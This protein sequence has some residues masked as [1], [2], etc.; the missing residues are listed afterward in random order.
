MPFLSQ[1]VYDWLKAGARWRDSGIVFPTGIGT[2]HDPRRLNEDF[3]KALKQADRMDD[4]LGSVG[5]VVTAEPVRP[6]P[7][8]VGSA[9]RAH[10]MLLSKLGTRV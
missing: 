7:Y 8:P 6:R 10:S 3:M 4:V 9:T 1:G 5:Q 2:P